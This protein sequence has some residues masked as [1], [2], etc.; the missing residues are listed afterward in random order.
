MELNNIVVAAVELLAYSLHVDNIAVDCH[1]AAV[2][3]LSG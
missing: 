2:R 1:L 3:W